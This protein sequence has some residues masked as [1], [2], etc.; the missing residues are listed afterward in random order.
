[1]T[2]RIHYYCSGIQLTS[3]WSFSCSDRLHQ[4][5]ALT[6]VTYLAKTI[7]HYKNCGIT[8]LNCVYPKGG[9]RSARRKPTISAECWQTLFA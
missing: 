3:N 6:L 1:M 4:V 2:L 7:N 8:F 5:F 9:N